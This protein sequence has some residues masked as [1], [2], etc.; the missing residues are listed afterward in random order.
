MGNILQSAENDFISGIRVLLVEARQSVVKQ[1]NATMIKTYYEIGRRIV[2]Q[3]QQGKEVANYGDYILVRLSES[4]SGSFGKGFSKRNLELMRQFYL[5]Y[6][7]AKSPISQSLS[8]TH[9]IR[10]M[11]ISDPDERRFYEIE[12]ANNNWSVRELNRQFDSALYQRLALSRDKEA[13]KELA[14]K[15]QTIEKPEDISKDPYVLEFTGLPELP[16]YTES[17][18]E[19]RLIDELQTFLLELGKGFSFVGRQQR[20]TIDED[21]YFVDLVFYNRFLRA[22]VLVDLKI[23]QLKHQDLGQM[24][25]YVHY[26]DRFVKMPDENKTIGIILCRDKKDALV[27]ITLPDETNPIFASKYQTVLPNKE[28]LKALIEK[29]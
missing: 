4:L 24:Q 14:I 29:R 15:G 27:E 12:A 28:E 17:K 9:Y 2:E 13:V 22:F 16:Q 20:I 5:T 11:R 18:L 21:H 19:Q 26:Y 8:W 23:G 25:M 1:V 10:L 3:E 6:R 7:I